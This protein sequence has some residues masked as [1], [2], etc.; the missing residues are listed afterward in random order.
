MDSRVAPRSR[1]NSVVVVIAAILVPAVW[2]CCGAPSG[3]GLL[4]PPP[5]EPPEASF[6]PDKAFVAARA[7]A[8]GAEQAGGEGILTRTLL[9]TPEEAT[10]DIAVE[11][12]DLLI[13]PNQQVA[14]QAAADSALYEV[15]TGAGVVTISGKAQE[16][17]SGA[18]FLVPQGESLTIQS[19]GADPI[20][21]RAHI[22][23]AR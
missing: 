15:L 14:V 21:L 11:I 19:R 8:L 4:P 9:T 3:V 13:P 1:G 18:M 10:A 17:S 5:G 22:I 20:V 2:L 12:R 6:K 23:K 16:V 7:N